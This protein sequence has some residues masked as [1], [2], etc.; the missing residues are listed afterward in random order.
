MF[1]ALLEVPDHDLY[2][3]LRGAAPVPHTHDTPVFAR[4]K[5]LCERKHPA[6]NV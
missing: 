3:W 5:A 2:D 1:A 6:W 4:L